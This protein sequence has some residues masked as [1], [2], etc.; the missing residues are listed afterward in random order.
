MLVPLDH[1]N[2]KFVRIS[3]NFTNSMLKSWLIYFSL[4]SN[5]KKLRIGHA[6]EVIPFK[7]ASLIITFHAWQILRLVWHVGS[8]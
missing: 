2:K 7:S 5:L 6:P 3:R 1:I 8:Q 4:H